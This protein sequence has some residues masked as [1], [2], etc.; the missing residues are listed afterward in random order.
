[1]IR[2][3][4]AKVNLSL[5]VGKKRDDGF[6]EISSIFYPIPLH[7]ILEIT[8]S[9]KLVFHNSGLR[10][11]GNPGDNLCL[12]AY[13]LLSREKHLP[14]VKIHLH[15]IIPMGAGLGGGSSDASSVLIVLNELFKLG[16]SNKELQTFSSELGSDCPFFI[17]NKPCHVQGRGEILEPIEADLQGWTLVLVYPSIHIPTGQAYLHVGGNEIPDQALVGSQPD[18]GSMRNDFQPW[19]EKEYPALRD[20]GKQ[21]Q[22]LGAEY[23]SMSGSGSSYFGLFRSDPGL[24]P[25]QFSGSDFWALNLT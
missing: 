9:E 17:E 4:N 12:K 6:H 21:L 7:D 1:M 2:F 13:Q 10:I 14:P 8:P 16:F 20:I 24:S 19:A 22:S 3:P 11:P 25:D 23:V 18:F 15:K 5:R